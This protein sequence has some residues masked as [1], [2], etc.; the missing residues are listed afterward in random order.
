MTRALTIA[1][2]DS[3]AASGV[4]A[5]LRVFA[6]RGVYGVC[7]VTLVAAQDTR[8]V[9]RLYK[10]PASIV[11]A[12]I[13]TVLRD[14]GADACKIGWFRSPELTTLIAGRIRRREIRQV[15]LDPCLWSANGAVLTPPR[16]VKRLVRELLPCTEVLCVT[17][18]ELSVLAA[19][20]IETEEELRAAAERVRSLG[21]RSLV[22][23]DAFGEHPVWAGIGAELQ[24]VAGRTTGATRLTDEGGLF[25]AAL[26][27]A[28][29]AGAAL[30]EAARSAAAFVEAARADAQAP[31][32][33]SLVW[34]IPD[35]GVR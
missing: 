3:A 31:G 35:G 24:P 1:A 29:A 2:S 4:Q 8:A 19:T 20:P 5:D 22:V 16:T 33:G 10:L 13:D 26:T 28:L 27:A 23:E 17:V 7:A 30:P 12:Q 11:G 25:S 34:S 18:R 9:R 15:V 32:R 6:A 21:A 14:I